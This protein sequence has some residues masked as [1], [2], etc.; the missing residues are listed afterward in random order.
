[1][2]TNRSVSAE[3]PRVV[4]IWA[5]MPLLGLTA[6]LEKVELSTPEP[7]STGSGLE[8]DGTS[9]SEFAA[10]RMFLRD[11]LQ[12]SRIDLIPRSGINVLNVRVNGTWV[13]VI[14]PEGKIL[15]SA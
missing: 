7:G 5:V 15:A 10:D 11:S 13:P 1:M 12:A 9:Q 14:S 3:F 6:C 8:G 4:G 2:E